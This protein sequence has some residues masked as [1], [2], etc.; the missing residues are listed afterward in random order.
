M[1]IASL[2]LGIVSI[3]F[4]FLGLLGTNS[5]PFLFI[6]YNKFVSPSFNYLIVLGGFIGVLAIIIGAIALRKKQLSKKAIKQ[7]I[8]GIILGILPSFNFI[9]I[10][11]YV[12]A[13]LLSGEL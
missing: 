2:V 12:I 1:A 9:K 3:F 7:T 8:I 4:V 5:I 6:K 13:V 11:I 10:V